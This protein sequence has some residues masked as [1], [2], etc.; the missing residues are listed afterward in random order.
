MTSMRCRKP[1]RKVE[2]SAKYDEPDPLCVY[3]VSG[4]E[5]RCDYRTPDS[6]CFDAPVSM[7]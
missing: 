4:K 2:Y 7:R 3:W 5:V 1:E 6:F